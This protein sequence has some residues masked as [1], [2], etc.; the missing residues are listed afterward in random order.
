MGGGEANGV[1]SGM[2]DDKEKHGMKIHPSSIIGLR[3]RLSTAATRLLN[4]CLPCS[5][6]LLVVQLLT[7]YVLWYSVPRLDTCKQATHS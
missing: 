6:E 4:E 5:G 3:R 2:K 1:E 7:W